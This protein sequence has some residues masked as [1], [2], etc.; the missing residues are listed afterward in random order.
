MPDKSEPMTNFKATIAYDGGAYVGWQRQA[1]GISVQ[2]RV[3]EVLA[4]IHKQ[5][6]MVVHGAGRTDAGVHA[7]GMVA[8]F[9]ASKRHGTAYLLRALNALLPEDIRVLRIQKVSE[10]FHAR[11]SARRKLYRYRIYHAPVADPLRRQQVWFVHK[12]L[13]IAAM[14]AAARAFVGK[15]DF[16]S[17]AV[18]PGYERTTMVR[19]VRR[20]VVLRRGDEI[21]I[22]ME[23]DGFLYKMVRSI[24]G[25]LVEVGTGKRTAESVRGMLKAKQRQQG[26]VVAPA[27]GLCLVRVRY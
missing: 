14:R 3:E 26:G 18:N 16:S 25:T 19:H 12:S 22:E 2:Q 8:S 15:Q 13:D 10:K 4:R 17:V 9:H 27:H 23:A 21:H 1:N 11:F 6:K 5:Q 7:L 24:A 20:C